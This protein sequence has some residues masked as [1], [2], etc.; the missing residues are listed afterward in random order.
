MKRELLI[1][2]F[3]FFYNVAAPRLALLMTLCWPVLLGVIG[4]LL[5]LLKMGVEEE[6]IISWSFFFLIFFLSGIEKHAVLEDI[7]SVCSCYGARLVLY[8]NGDVR[9]K[10]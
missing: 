2:G 5:C 1:K 4:K 10:M 6:K 7:M 9:R 3:N 8:T